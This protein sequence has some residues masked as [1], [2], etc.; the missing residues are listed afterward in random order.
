MNKSF[1]VVVF[2][3]FV[4]G[5]IGACLVQ[6]GVNLYLSKSVAMVR[7]DDLLASHI[8]EYAAKGLGDEE[9]KGVSERYVKALDKAIKEVSQAKRVDL[10]V[11][12][13]LV[14]EVPD[15]TDYIKAYIEVNM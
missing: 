10:F 4:S 6:I 8:S 12:G 2:V 7:V 14:S 13:A 9:L 3:S 1:A 11:G 5:V 15:Y